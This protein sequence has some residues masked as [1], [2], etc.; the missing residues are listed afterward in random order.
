MKNFELII[1]ESFIQKKFNDKG[2]LVYFV[3]PM[4]LNSF[5]SIICSLLFMAGLLG[6]YV[7]KKRVEEKKPELYLM[8]KASIYVK[9]TEL[10]EKKVRFVSKKLG[11]APEWLMSV[12]YSESRFN[13]TAL[14]FRGSGAI[15]L[16][17]FM[18]N[19][20]A[21]FKP[22]LSTNL[23]QKMNELEQ[24]ELVYSYLEVY[25]KKYG[26]YTSLTDLY[27]AILYPKA[28]TY[29]YCGVLYSKPTV[30]YKQNV[31]LDEN[32][33]GHVT[34]GDIDTRMQRLYGKAYSVNFAP[35]KEDSIQHFK[36]SFTSV[37]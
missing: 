13:A 4:Q 9:N 25:R 23:V 1:K 19:T 18:P 10:F 29:D 27:L 14:N 17:Q 2:K 33:N 15:G 32:K 7:E 30:A 16:I 20:L 37:E 31:G 22:K 3:K 12:M 8:D 26:A 34:V 11:I 6:F 24:L 35:F 21:E 5:V 28:R 36:E